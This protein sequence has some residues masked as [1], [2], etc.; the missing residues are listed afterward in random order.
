MSRLVGER[1]QILEEAP[2]DL[3]HAALAHDRLDENP[4]GLIADCGLDG[5]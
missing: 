5:A 4:G 2:G 3:A 1:A